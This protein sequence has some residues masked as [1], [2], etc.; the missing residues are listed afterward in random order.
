MHLLFCKGHTSRNC[1][2]ADVGCPRCDLPVGLC[3][4]CCLYGAAPSLATSVPRTASLCR[5]HFWSKHNQRCI[6]KGMLKINNLQFRPDDWIFSFGGD[7]FPEGMERRGNAGR[8]CSGFVGWPLC[9]MYCRTASFCCPTAS[10]LPLL[11]FLQFPTAVF[12]GLALMRH[13]CTCECRS[14]LHWAH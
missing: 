3:T 9:L 8:W 5:S 2:L 6:S 11:L 13:C 12:V 14:L 4:V 1:H 10:V 7:G